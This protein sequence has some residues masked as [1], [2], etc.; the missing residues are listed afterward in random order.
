MRDLPGG[1]RWLGASARVGAAR[2][3][4]LVAASLLEH[5]GGALGEMR[6]V[7]YVA[8]ARRQLAPYVTAAVAQFRSGR[9]TLTQRA[10]AKLRSIV[11]GP[12]K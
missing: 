10:L 8:F 3:G 4:Q 5:Y 12:R 9:S 11:S 2:A 6:Q 1:A 7:G